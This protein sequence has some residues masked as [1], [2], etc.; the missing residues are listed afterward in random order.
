MQGIRKA[1]M[2]GIVS[3]AVAACAM[4]GIKAEIGYLGASPS[5]SA[6]R[7]KVSE[8]LKVVLA[9]Q[10][11]DQFEVK[12]APSMGSAYAEYRKS[13]ADALQKT[14]SPNFSEV[15]IADR[16][17]GHGLEL[18]VAK[19][20]MLTTTTIRYQAL[21]LSD[22][23]EIIDV[24]G[25]TKGRAIAISATPFNASSGYTDAMVTL[26]REA[27]EKMCAAIYDD[28]FRS[29][30]QRPADFWDKRVAAAH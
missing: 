9:S 5:P 21:L 29:G 8:P 22:G 20:E 25:E 6:T 13:L 19:A 7:L 1:A 18:V 4:G 30:R 26:S 17:T 2:T 23:K 11:P 28:I 10:I 3:V 24:A 16:E 14:F 15:V 12:P 27:V